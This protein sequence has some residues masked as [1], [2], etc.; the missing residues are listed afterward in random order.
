M[1]MSLDEWLQQVIARNTPRI[2]VD[3]ERARELEAMVDR[4]ESG[5]EAWEVFAS[6]GVIPVRWLEDERRAFV[7]SSSVLR[8]FKRARVESLAAERVEVHSGLRCTATR[9]PADKRLAVAVAVNSAVI[10]EAE[11]L[12]LHGVQQCDLFLQSERRT[13]S[14]ARVLWGLDEEVGASSHRIEQTARAMSSRCALVWSAKS[15]DGVDPAASRLLIDQIRELGWTARAFSKRSPVKHS[16][17][18][19]DRERWNAILEGLAAV[20]RPDGSAHVIANLTGLDGSQP[21]RIEPHEQRNPFEPLAAVE[22]MNVR[23]AAEGERWVF[24]TVP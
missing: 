14:D 24:L 5:F 8:R 16:A 2:P 15:L 9:A 3:R 4:C 19:A 18:A 20:K 6:R 12:A 21:L 7:A 13:Q 11:R 17:F 22:A 23:V 1:T 10:E